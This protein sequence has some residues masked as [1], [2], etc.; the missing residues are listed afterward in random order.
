MPYGDAAEHL[1][2]AFTFHEDLRTG[3]WLRPFTR[4]AVYAPL[5]PF[6]GGLSIFVG[7]RSVSTPIVAQN[8]LYVPALAL[9]CFGTARLA[10]GSRAAFL[11][12]V[13][14]LGSPLISEQ[15]HVFMLDAP[16]AALVAMTV[17]LLLASDR[18][19]RIDVAALAGCIAGLGMIS[20]QSFPLYIAGLLLVILAR[21]GWRHRRGFA[22]FLLVTF[23]LAA[24]WYIVQLTNLGTF[25]NVAGEGI[26]V[27]PLARPPLL[28]TANLEWYF[29][30]LA[31]GLLFVPLLSFAVIGV[32]TASAEVARG[33][34][35][36]SVVPE[37]LG[38]G[39][40]AWLA[41]TITPHHDVRY[42]M[43]LIVF[44]AVLG[45]G[46]IV[47]LP[48]SAGRLATVLLLIAVA[49]STL[50][51]TFGVGHKRDPFPILPGNRAAALGE[52]VPRLHHW[53][54]YSN[55]N[56]MVSGP[57]NGGDILGL[58][59]K[60]RA[61]GVRSAAIINEAAPV[62]YADFNQNGLLALMKI[63]K[64][65]SLDGERI[66][67]SSLEQRQAIFFNQRALGSAP[68]CVPMT[69]G[70][71]IWIRRGDP[72]DPRTPDYCPRSWPRYYGP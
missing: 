15:F 41:L 9:G 66:A 71:G 61:D 33:R 29:W 57:R 31:N 16:L 5:T 7:G 63:A 65:S 20:K 34:R 51:A 52:G 3:N 44:L 45:T 14:A 54:I 10:Y 64:L 19:R 38:G 36:A 67:L 23:I 68:S 46:W 4:T 43:P 32:V 40:L 18:F 48:R 49:A 21:G 42:T 59:E 1:L 69:G 27:P 12:V 37:L 56:F 50:G 11:A 30:A 60:M 22:V 2:T 55:Y 53:T 70:Q 25:V 26:T 17:W 28:S 39:L 6:V 13:F 47:Q 72:S 24:P 35:T 58:L 8:L 62:W